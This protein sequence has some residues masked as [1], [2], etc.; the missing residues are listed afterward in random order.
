MNRPLPDAAALD[1]DLRLQQMLAFARFALGDDHLVHLV[2]AVVDARGALVAI[3]VGQR[4]VVGHAQRAVHLDRAIDHALQHVGDEE[5]DQRDLIARGV[6]ALLL[7]RPRGVQHHQPRGV[8]LG[9]RL[10]DPGLARSAGRQRLRPGPAR[11]GRRGGTS[12]RRR[13][14]R[15]RSS[16]CSGG[17]GPGRGRSC[18]MAKPRALRAEPVGLRHAHAGVA[19]ISAWLAQPSPA[20]PMIVMLRT[21]SKPGV[22]VGTMIIDARGRAARRRGWSPPS[23]S[24]TRRR[25]RRR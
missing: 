24:R 5:L 1:E 9:A 18:A 3:P 12:G 23:R 4:G 7:D 17:C 13:A 16:A 11:A 8:D 25:R 10:G 21:S 15:C 22:S 19:Q 14:R 6:E 2:G 20:S